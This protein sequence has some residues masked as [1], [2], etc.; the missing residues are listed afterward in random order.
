M[1]QADCGVVDCDGIDLQWMQQTSDEESDD[2]NDL[3]RDG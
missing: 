1:Q 2:G 3:D